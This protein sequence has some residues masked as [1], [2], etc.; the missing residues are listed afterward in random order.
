M[1]YWWD[2]ESRLDYKIEAIDARFEHQYILTLRSLQGGTPY[3]HLLLRIPR[4]KLEHPLHV[5]G[6]IVTSSEP[7]DEKRFRV[8]IRPRRKEELG[9]AESIDEDVLSEISAIAEHGF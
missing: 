2:D 5:G 7:L 3:A 6:W 8:T 4:V 1:T 9:L